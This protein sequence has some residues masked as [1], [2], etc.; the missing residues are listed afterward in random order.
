MLQFLRSRV[1]GVFGILLIA[2]L[3]LAFGLW[4][5][6]DT[7]TGF[8]N[9]EIATVGSQKIERTEYQIRYMQRTQDLS[10]QLGTPIT[11]AA[12]R[13]LGIEAQIMSTLLGSAALKEAADEMGLAHGDA[14]IA[15]SIV[16]DANFAGPDGSFDEPTFR[17]VLRQ[18]GLN[19]KLFVSDQR[20]FHILE[21]LSAATVDDGLVPDTLVDGLFKHF[22]ERRVAR[23]LILTLDQTDD[24]GDPTAEELE[25]FFEQTKLRFAEPE[26]R[27]AQALVVSP[28]RFA[29]LISIDQATLQEEYE[30]NLDKYSVPERRSID[31]LVLAD[32]AEVD[33]V[34]K[35]LEEEAAFAE[36]VNAVGQT[37]DNTDLGTVERG[38]L[39]SSDLADIAFEM[40]QGAI[41]E[42][43]EGP[44]GYVVLRVRDITEGATLPLELVADQLRSEIVYDRALDDMIA[45]SET[46]EDELAGGETLA[47]IGQRFDLDVID[48]DEINNDGTLSDGKKPVLLARYDNITPVLF[49]SAVGE[50]IPMLEMEDGTYVWTR[51]TG[52]TPSKV[53]P[54]DDIRKAVAAQWET[55][56]KTKLLQAMA[57]HM[58]KKGNE[59]G[60]FKKV[61]EDFDRKPLLSEP[62]TRQVSNDTFS[63]EAVTQLFAVKKGNF[64]W[65]NVGFGGE[66]IV[67]QVE[68]II[69]AEVKDGEAKE[70][71]FTGEQRKYY[72]DLTNQFVRSLQQDYGVSINQ[73]NLERATSELVSR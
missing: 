16:A 19:E 67:M 13:N 4:G 23:Y 53:P 59:I 47:S 27:S 7:F 29:E 35:L 1:S 45:F 56:E 32:D 50:E 28:A 63:D 21:Q 61:A 26:K 58:V 17:A 8:S 48:L 40:E 2:V 68:D 54:L 5:I 37:L 18:N 41:S 49:E 39:I 3:V 73:A 22:L 51:L 11:P 70:L 36:I 12:A 46:V 25:S 10:R 52:I 72:V 69:D 24:V 30:L 66:I 9:A 44:L 15:K 14:A 6:A 42:I 71:I 34:R 33:A 65:A 57:E 60:S 38:D 43:I 31:Q 20:R 55:A 64:A 62:M